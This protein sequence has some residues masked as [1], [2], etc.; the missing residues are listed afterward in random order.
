MSSNRY[1]D[2]QI[3]SDFHEAKEIEDRI[4]EAACKC[5]YDDDTIFA[6][7]LSVEEA[8][9]NAIRHGNL[10]DTH[11]KVGVRYSVSPDRIDIYVTDEGRGFSPHEVPDP[12]APE[13][14]ENPSGRGIML[15]R[16][17]MNQVE[18]NESGNQIHLVKLNQAG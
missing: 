3:P 12:T 16:A 7:R 2:I 14:L 5:G 9:S 11:K 18:F 8:L 10:Y 15:M 17:Y 6:L 4:V 13:N 1:T